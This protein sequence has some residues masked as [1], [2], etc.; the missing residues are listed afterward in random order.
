MALAYR[1]TDQMT[2]RDAAAPPDGIGEEHARPIAAWRRHASPLGLGVFA[3][4]VVASLSGLLGRERTWS[5]DTAGVQLDVHGPEI[6]RNGEF[7]EIRIGVRGS[8]P[9]TE[10]V[11]G[12]EDALWE[13][14]TVNTMIPAATEEE[15]ADGEVRFTFAELPAETSFLFKID[16]QVNPDILGGNGGAVTLYDGEEPLARVDVGIMVLP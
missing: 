8:E 6:I 14:I 12:V 10:L 15:N 5:A 9:V 13:D 1:S 16:L 7:F 11:I 3:V 2:T 4:V